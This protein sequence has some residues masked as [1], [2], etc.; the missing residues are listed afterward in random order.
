MHDEWR[1][2]TAVQGGSRTEADDGDFISVAQLACGEGV[3]WVSTSSD[4]PRGGAVS[5]AYLELRLR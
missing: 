4:L 2:V 3:L 1:R 5:W